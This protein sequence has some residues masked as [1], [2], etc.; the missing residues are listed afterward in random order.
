VLTIGAASSPPPPEEFNDYAA[1]ILSE[2][3]AGEVGANANVPVITLKTI[4]H[5]KPGHIVTIEPRT[6]FVMTVF[7]PESRHNT[8]F[9]TERLQQQLPN[10]FAAAKGCR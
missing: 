9:T 7:R 4:D 10:V 1:I 6:G 2:D 5:L 3:V 8:I